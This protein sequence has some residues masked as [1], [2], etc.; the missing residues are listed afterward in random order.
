MPGVT[1]L[2]HPCLLSFG[3]VRDGTMDNSQGCVLKL[4]KAEHLQGNTITEALR[5]QI[6][7]QKQLPEQLQAL[8]ILRGSRFLQIY[9][10]LTRKQ[11]F[12]FLFRFLLP[13]VYPRLDP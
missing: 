12:S 10:F 8:N 3:L 1:R 2:Y 7:V 13:P 11:G 5:M 4:M 9:L 6:E